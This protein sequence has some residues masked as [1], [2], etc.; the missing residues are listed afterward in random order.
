MSWRTIVVSP[1]FDDA[2]MS[3]A[4]VLARDEGSSVIVTVLGGAAAERESAWDRLCGFGSAEETARERLAEDAR[5]CEVLGADQVALDYPDVP[6]RALPLP[7]L[8]DFLAA[9][10]TSDTRV[11]VPMGIG[12]ADHEAVR[13]RTLDALRGLGAGE[14]LAYADLPYASAAREWG[15]P[16]AAEALA[17]KRPVLALAGRHRL[18]P[19]PPVRLSEREWALKRR[20]VLSYASQ[21]AP[22][23]CEYGEFVAM[24]GPLQHELL[25][26]LEE[27]DAE[28]NP[29]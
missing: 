13:D 19:E 4:G 29:R 17:D 23:A 21:I 2:A 25:W 14:V 3:V 5:A 9:N 1:H 16:G 20:A 8:A 18:R 28:P 26:T 27:E 6:A 10:V 22:L 11:L 24:P 12:N 7:G 15:T